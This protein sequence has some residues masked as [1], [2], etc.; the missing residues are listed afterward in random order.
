MKGLLGK[1]KKKKKNSKFRKAKGPNVGN[2]VEKP[3]SVEVIDK[4]KILTEFEN[5]KVFTQDWM[6]ISSPSFR[7]VNKFPSL[8]LHD[9]S[10][11]NINIDTANFRVNESFVANSKNTNLP[12][13][14]LYFWFTV[15]DK[16]IYYSDSKTSLVVRGNL[17]LKKLVGV[18]KERKQNSTCFEVS[19]NDNSKWK[20]C[21]QDK[22]TRYKW[23]CYLNTILGID[24]F[25]CTAKPSD[26]NIIVED[27][28]VTDPVILIPLPSKTCNEKWNYANFGNDWEC[29]C[30]DGKTQSPIDIDTGNLSNSPVKPVFKY[31]EFK[32]DDSDLFVFENGSV[33]VK[34]SKFG[35]VVTLDGNSFVAKEI[36]FH[37]PSQHKINGKFYDMEME[38][39]H[40]GESADVITEH[41]TLSIMFL[42]KAG[43]Y[44]KFIDDLDFFNLPG[45]TSKIKKFKSRIN[46]NKVF[47]DITQAEF[48]RWEEFSFFTY[49][50]SL[51]APPCTEKTIVYVKKTPIYIG[52]TTLQL[53][54][55]ALKRPDTIDDAGS[56]SINN[57]EPTN[58]RKTQPLN[59]RRVYFYN[60]VEPVLELEDMATQEVSTKPVGHY[61]KVQKKM[62]NYFH[63]TGPTP[64]EVPGSFVVSE[65]EAK[66]IA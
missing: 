3:K 35:R 12:T 57:S 4:N 65:N 24:D 17:P 11:K 2:K 28:K 21:A 19:D 38:I 26:A 13:E 31:E 33:K 41:L 6:K 39:I 32:P 8:L 46:L 48:P 52:N 49:E 14:D 62:I 60:H 63:V 40:V 51:S 64:S 27:T 47:Y 43:V 36:I 22:E 45:P 25:E 54:R 29:D 58:V 18:T 1:D 37:T 5:L 7:D 34:T 61:E 9:F 53:F 10:E 59:G 44:N 20:L 30:I 23:I 50:G 15:N 16:N 42:S 66:G 56:I 55:E